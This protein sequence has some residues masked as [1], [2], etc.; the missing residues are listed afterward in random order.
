M[1]PALAIDEEPRAPC[2]EP[3]LTKAAERID[4]AAYAEVAL[5]LTAL[6]VPPG[7][8]NRLGNAIRAVRGD[9]CQHHFMGEYADLVWSSIREN[10]KYERREPS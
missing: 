1:Q 2:P 8:V 5:A 9:E 4:P 10:L 3:R 7:Q 6:D